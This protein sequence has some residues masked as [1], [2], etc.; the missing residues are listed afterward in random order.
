ML[1]VRPGEVARK[2][3][4]D[5]SGFFCFDDR[6]WARI[7]SGPPASGDSGNFQFETTRFGAN[8][9]GLSRVEGLPQGE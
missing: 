5:L 8:V 3:R 2:I 1:L 4:E 9:T 6:E 7:Q